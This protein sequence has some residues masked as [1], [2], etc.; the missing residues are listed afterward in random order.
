M[1][2]HSGKRNNKKEKEWI[3]KQKREIARET[4]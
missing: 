2:G 1:T 4:E 3:I